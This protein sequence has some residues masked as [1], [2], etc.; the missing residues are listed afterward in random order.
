MLPRI[1][2]GEG[3][4]M[5]VSEVGSA[6][7]SGPTSVCLDRE[8]FESKGISQEQTLC[9]RKNCRRYASEGNK[10]STRTSKMWF[11]GKEGNNKTKSFVLGLRDR[12]TSK[13]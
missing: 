2:E 8:W 6:C 10:G 5:Y 4:C 11:G 12:G 3:T 1:G 7:G 13:R 9:E